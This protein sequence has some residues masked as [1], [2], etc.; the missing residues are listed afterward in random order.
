MADRRCAP[1]VVVEAHSLPSDHA[2]LATHAALERLCRP[3]HVV[4]GVATTPRVGSPPGS[5]TRWIV[6]RDGGRLP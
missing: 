2:L 6:A 5:R 1:P 4:S 3:Q